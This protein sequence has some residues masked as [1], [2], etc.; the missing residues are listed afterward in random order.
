M[1]WSQLRIFCFLISNIYDDGDIY[2]TGRRPSLAVLVNGI[3]L[4][5]VFAT[6]VKRKSTDR[7]V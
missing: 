6:V 4:L 3:C 7:I 5:L 2:D 1:T